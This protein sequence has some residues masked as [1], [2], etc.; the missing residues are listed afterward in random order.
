[1]G[2]K[3]LLIPRITPHHTEEQIYP[4]KGGS[5]GTIINVIPTLWLPNMSLLFCLFVR[6]LLCL[7]A[8]F[9]Y[10]TLQVSETQS[11][12]IQTLGKFLPQLSHFSNC[13]TCLQII[14]P[15]KSQ[16]Q[17]WLI[18]LLHPWHACGPPSLVDHTLNT[19]SQFYFIFMTTAHLGPLYLWRGCT[20]LLL[21][22]CWLPGY[23]TDFYA[24]RFLKQSFDLISP[25]LKT[26]STYSPLKLNINSPA[27]HSRN[28]IRWLQDIFLAL[29][30]SFTPY[31]LAKWTR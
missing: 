1:M 20:V 19:I 23:L 7:L 6:A 10:N 24:K 16:Q 22:P 9:S 15:S 28:V 27:Q 17:L 13:T 11:A 30:P 3:S 26:F 14:G 29:S 12:L 2:L 25:L 21:S 31:M 18:L 4:E 5:E 8:T